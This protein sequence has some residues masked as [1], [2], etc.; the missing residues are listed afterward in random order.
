MMFKGKMI[1]LSAPSGAGKT[2]L[3]KHLLE[4]QNNLKF[5]IS[6]TTRKQR[7]NEIDGKDYYFLS[8]QEFKKNI[9]ANLFAE[10]EEVYEDLF[11]GTLK[12]EINRIWA[13]ESHIAFDIDVQGGINLKNLYKEKALSIFIQPPSIKILEER[14]RQRNTEIENILVERIEK[15]KEE[16]LL[17]NNFDE[18]ILNNNLDNAKKEITNLVSTFLL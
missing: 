8:P 9:E 1:I 17:V 15:A 5:S 7:E 14:L 13:N 16:L 4:V 18:T 11:Y 6:C 3:I 12:S 10:W 2:T